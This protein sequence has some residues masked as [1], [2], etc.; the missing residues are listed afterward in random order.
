MKENN[1]IFFVF[2]GVEI[3]H[4]FPD[5]PIFQFPLENLFNM[6]MTQLWFTVQ[7]YYYALPHSFTMC[8]EF[9]T[10]LHIFFANFICREIEF[11]F[12]LFFEMRKSKKNREDLR[13]NLIIR[14]RVVFCG[15]LSLLNYVFFIVFFFFLYYEV[16]RIS[17][18]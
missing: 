6:S 8:Q 15:R 11:I 2:A 13:R 1:L 5:F 9:S 3:F 14:K 17:T 7:Y 10:I 16:F 18:I 4:S 12:R